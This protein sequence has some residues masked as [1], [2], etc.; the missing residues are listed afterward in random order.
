MAQS[1]LH[2]SLGMAVGTLAALP[3]LWRA[4][5]RGRPVTRPVARWCLLAYALGLFAVLPAIIRRLTGDP[6]LGSGIGWNVFLFYPLLARLDLPSIVGGELA[7]AGLFCMQYGVILLAIRRAR[8][9]G[10]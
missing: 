6:Q 2:F 9:G 10:D 3:P 1:T 4:W 5:R 8:R 7:L